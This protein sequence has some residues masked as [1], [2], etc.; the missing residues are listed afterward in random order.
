M[1][2]DFSPPFDFGFCRWCARWLTSEQFDGLS[3]QARQH[4][5]STGVCPRCLVVLFPGMFGDASPRRPVLFGSVVGVVA[6]GAVPSEV[7]V[8]PFRHDPGRS[9]L[10]F[11]PHLLVRAGSALAPLD[12][13]AELGAL[14]AL[15]PGDSMRVVTLDS[16]D[17]PLLSASLSRSHVHVCL[18]AAVAAA[19]PPLFPVLP[20]LPMAP[21]P[22]AVRLDADVPWADAFGT[23]LLPL[24]QLLRAL[25]LEAEVGLADA[26][27][28]SALRQCALV[29]RLLHLS[30]A[31]GQTVFERWLV[32]WPD[33]PLLPSPADCLERCSDEIA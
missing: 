32:E 33:P 12:P 23:P 11:E 31:A 10:R 26:C 8:L 19:L 21:Q 9:R 20:A 4:V 6:D 27:E 18:H 29:A 24:G 22:R 30:T 15:C 16:L 25:D 5:V 2:D 7:A 14:R 28:G 3:E 1:T 17:D 13:P